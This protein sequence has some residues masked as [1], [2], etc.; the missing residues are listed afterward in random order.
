MTSSEPTGQSLPQTVQYNAQRHTRVMRT[1]QHYSR[2]R[3]G[4]L[5]TGSIMGLGLMM[6]R[7]V[8][9]FSSPPGTMLWCRVVQQPSKCNDTRSIFR[10]K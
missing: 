5:S 3:K 10:F 4:M 9:V 7:V 2:S 1:K 8:E 6:R